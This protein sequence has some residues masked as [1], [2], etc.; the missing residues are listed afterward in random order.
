MTFYGELLAYK[1]KRR[2]FL[3]SDQHGIQCWSNNRRRLVSCIEDL[4]SHNCTECRTQLYILHKAY[5]TLLLPSS[6]L[7][8]HHPESMSQRLKHI[9]IL[10]E[11]ISDSMATGCRCSNY[12]IALTYAHFKPHLMTFHPIQTDYSYVKTC[13]RHIRLCLICE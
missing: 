4:V 12:E 1:N 13:F 9:K 3:S 7:L 6:K 5:H 8:A 10:C 2:P 11:L